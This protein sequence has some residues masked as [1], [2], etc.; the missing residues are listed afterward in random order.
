MYLCR[1]DAKTHRLIA[2][3]LA[4]CCCLPLRAQERDYAFGPGERHTILEMF[5]PMYF[6]SGIPVNGPVSKESADVKFQYSIKLN[7]FRNIAASGV[8]LFFGYTQ[9][10]VWNFYA[11]SSPFYDSTYNPGFYAQKTW[12]RDGNPVHTLLGGLEH[13]SNGRSDAYSRS[14]NYGFATYARHF[15]DLVLAA[16]LRIGSGWYGDQRT[17]D[18]PLR[19]IG[20]LR[21]SAAY[22]TPD[23]SW[24][25]Q[26]GVTPLLNRSIANVTLEAGWRLAR[27]KDNPFLFVQFHYGYEV[28]RDCVDEYGDSVLW[29]DGIVSYDHGVPTP[30]RAMIRFGILVSP[31]SFLRAVL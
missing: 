12:Y 8:D 29:P 13:R 11:H 1:V 10:S 19:Y 2:A 5:R 28:F 26:A 31:H 6:I 23:R 30:P 17:W 15:P 25:F 24:E 9:T 7:L 3:L 27:R 16:T 18:L 20:L 21:L 14:T 4:V 22:Q